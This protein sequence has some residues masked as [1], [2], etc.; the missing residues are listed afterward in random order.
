MCP[1]DES[2]KVIEFKDYYLIPPSI[3]FFSESINYKVSKEDEKGNLVKD[4][5]VYDS[6]N[7]N[8]F[9]KSH[10]LFSNLMLQVYQ[11]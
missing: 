11:V 4:G 5:F 7:N 2:H 1:A 6:Q 3:Q 8:H 9:Y 10:G